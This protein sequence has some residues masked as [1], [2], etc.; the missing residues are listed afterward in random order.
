M[1][2]I[3]NNMPAINFIADFGVCAFLAVNQ[4]SILSR[5]PDIISPNSA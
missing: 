1:F 4:N 3:A 5:H 2:S